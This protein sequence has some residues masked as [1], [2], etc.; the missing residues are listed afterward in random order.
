[1]LDLRNK[2]ITVMGLGVHGGGLGVTRFLLE[3]G[4]HVIVTDLRSAEVLQPSLAALAGLPVEFVLGEHRDQDFELV[5][6]VI[7]NP[8]V[9]RESRYLQLARAA[10]VAIEMEMTLFFRLCPAPI[11]GITG[12]KGKTTT[13]TLTG[14]MLREVYPDTVVAGNLR[15]SALEQLPRITAQTPVV[16]ELSSWQLEG[17]GEAGL[18]PEYAC[19]TNLSPDH[20]DRYGSMADYGL[21]KQQIFL[22]QNPD[23]VVVLPK[24]DL[25]VNTWANEA[26][27]RVIWF[28]GNE[29]WPLGQLQGQHNALNIAAAAA[30]AQAYGISDAAIRTAIEHFAGVEHRMELVREITGVRFVNDTAAT[31]PTAAAAALN[32]M[33]SSVILI[34]GGA[35]K[36]LAWNPLVDAIQQSSQL[37]QLIILDGTGSP[38]LAAALGTEQER[39]QSFEQ[40]IRAAFELAE[41]GDTIL[42]SPGAASFGMFRNEFHRGEE[43]RR[44]VGLLAED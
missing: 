26:P 18:S 1:M 16:L 6:M 23:D 22:Y 21:A 7:R 33:S 14:A 42:L 24:H 34:A 38:A 2:R 44:I 3:Q 12:T 15:V 19:V 31:T 39:Y 13:T 8:G 29:G 40:A 27:G 5:D 28:D 32:S 35:D 36:K 9:P 30:L 41:A 17:L 20:L 43:F 37:K 10:G 4:A 25:I 11:I